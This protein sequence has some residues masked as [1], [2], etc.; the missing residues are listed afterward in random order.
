MEEIM[1]KIKKKKRLY[2]LCIMIFALTLSALVYNIFLLPLD[3]VSG[4]TSG[5]ATI[6]N[7]LYKI[8]PSIMILILSVICIIISYIFLGKEKTIGI[9]AASLLYPLLVKLT[10]PVTEIFKA[11]TNDLLITAIFAG[12]LSGISSGLMY[13]TGYNSGGF[14]V[15]CQI[16]YEKFKIPISKTNLVINL[17]IILIASLFFGTTNAMYAIILLYINNIVLDKVLLGISKNKAFY[18]ITCEEKQIKKYV[19]ESLKHSVTI[20]DVKGGFLEKK[21]KVLLVVIPSKEYYKLT[22]GIKLLDKEAFF[23]VT[24]AYE[25][26][27]AR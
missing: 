13:K 19:I 5:I 23:V 1:S 14:N 18:I 8:D 9:I 3:I 20:F 16:F 27:G 6:T 26:A 4:G 15:I 24:D 17:I 10:S 12:V 25:V 11:P 22:E 2:R 21:R 7:H